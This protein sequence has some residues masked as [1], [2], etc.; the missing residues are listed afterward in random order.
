MIPLT[1]D[2]QP[3]LSSKSVFISAGA[4]DPIVPGSETKALEDLLRSAG[5]SVTVRFLQSGHELTP[6]DVDL[7]RQWLTNLK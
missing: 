6:D 3:D 5:A 1:P 7:A 4:F 2:K